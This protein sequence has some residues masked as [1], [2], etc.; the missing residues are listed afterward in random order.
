MGTLC[1]QKI[2]HEIV[3]VDDGSTDSTWPKLLELS[4][5]VAVL[6]PVQNRG[7]HGFGRAVAQGFAC[8]S[9]DAVVTMMADE[10][11]DRRDVARYWALLNQGWDAVFGS[12]LIKGGSLIDY[13]WLKLRLNRIAH[14]VIGPM[15]GTKL[16]DTTNASKPSNGDPH[17]SFGAAL[18]VNFAVYFVTQRH[19]TPVPQNLSST[20]RSMKYCVCLH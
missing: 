17:T 4:Q 19:P 18:I 5:H 20:L 15:F 9:G 1:L 6:E 8:M 7:S 11:D 16:N 13:P 14:F 3:V 2:P 12:R 10:S